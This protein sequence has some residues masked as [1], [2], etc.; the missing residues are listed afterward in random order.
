MKRNHKTPPV[1]L[2]SSRLLRKENTPAEQALW[3]ALRDR[4]LHDLKFRRQAVIE[5]RYIV[6]FYCHASRLIVEV[7]GGIHHH[8][9]VRAAD[10]ERQEF[11]EMSGYRVI[12]FSNEQ[13]ESDLEIVLA[14]IA[15][16]C[17]GH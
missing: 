5:K 6:D 16:A 3:E 11:L 9:D 4:G 2:E 13:V 17:T 8:S 10:K 1:L 12:R 15:T 14:Q 7:D